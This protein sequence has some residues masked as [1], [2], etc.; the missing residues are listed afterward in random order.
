MFRIKICGITS[1]ADALDA[2]AAGA[3]AIGLNFYRQSPRC[4][5]MEHAS[6]IAVAMPQHVCR[7][8]VFVNATAGEIRGIVGSVG[9]DLVQLHGDEPPE[10]IAEL[11]GLN[12]MKAFRVL[13]DLSE[14]VEYLARCRALSAMPRMVLLDGLQP[15][16]YGGTG[17]PIKAEILR[18]CGALVG[19]LPFVLAGGMKPSNVAAAIA[20]VRP[21]AVDVAS[22]VETRPGKKSNPLVREFVAAAKVAFAQ[23]GSSGDGGVSKAPSQSVE[24]F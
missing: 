19:G 23:C 18:N 21:S 5:P 17:K 10:A 16:Q 7:V 15:G 22:G 3:D 9:L 2:A 20:A 4:C 13:D 1:V 12:V 24:E 11:G 6:K 14:V 8:G